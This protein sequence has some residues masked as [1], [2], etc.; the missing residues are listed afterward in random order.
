MSKSSKTCSMADALRKA[1][2]KRVRFSKDVCEMLFQRE[3]QYDRLPRQGVRYALGMS[4]T[5]FKKRKR[6]LCTAEKA[7]GTKVPW[8]TFQ[9]RKETLQPFL[10]NLD[11]PQTLENWKRYRNLKAVKVSR[12]H[13]GCSCVGK[14]QPGTCECLQNGIPCHHIKKG[15]IKGGGCRCSKGK[16]ANKNPRYVGQKKMLKAHYKDVFSRLHNVDGD[17]FP[18]EDEEI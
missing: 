14:C 13:M 2:R 10:E 16:C 1:L 12:M 5:H 17:Y 4:R 9:Q 18:E 15:S 8:L 7:S 3:P 6:P 11:S